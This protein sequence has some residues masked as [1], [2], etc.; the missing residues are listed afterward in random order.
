MSSTTLRDFV[1]NAVEMNRIRFADLRRLQRDILPYRITTSEEA[2]MLLSLDAT[3]ERADR[4][5]REY[6][7]PAVAQFVVWGMEP[8]GRVDQGKADWLLDAVALASPKVGSAIIR[9]VVIE[10]PLIEEAVALRPKPS[11]ATPPPAIV[12]EHGAVA[13]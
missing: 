12:S 13:P 3:V 4:N 10:A 2:E 7:V 6:L 9:H 8:V 11:R 5:W 1:L